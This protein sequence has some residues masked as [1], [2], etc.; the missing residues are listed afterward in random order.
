MSGLRKLLRINESQLN[1]INKFILDENNQIIND[2]IKVVEKYGGPDKINQKAKEAQNFDTIIGRLKEIKSQYISD[3]EWLINQRDDGSFIKMSEY[4]EKVIGSRASTLD[5][6]E[7]NAVTLEISALNFFPWLIAEA[8]QAIEKKELMPGRYIRVRNMKEQ[9]KDNGDLLAFSAAMQ[10]IGASYVQTLDTKGTDGS[11]I[12]LG[13]GETITGYFGG[14]GQPN[15]YA[16]KWVDEYLY[17]FTNYGIAQVLNINAG[18]IFL[19]FLLHKLGINNSFKISVYLGIDN[20]YSLFWTLMMA[21]LFARDNNTTSLVGLNFS[22]SVNNETIL[23]SDNIREAFGFGDMVRFE[24]HITETYK[25]IVRQPYNRRQEL[26]DLA[27][28]VKNISAKHEGG[29]VEIEESCEHPS[30][31]LEYFLTKEE[32]EEKNLM[33]SLERNYLD[34]HNALNKTAESLTKAG[35]CVIPAKNL[36]LNKF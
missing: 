14:I 3:L 23:R 30:D 6:N 20:P 18:T 1:E 10:I 19:A 7:R 33:K 9:L 4:R 17:Y 21:K 8:K 34:K 32:I 27:K 15:E 5:F 31:I 29:D 22:N 11:N 25:S 2:V 28:D 16:L 35:I 26:I 12:H 36:H 24:H 13:G